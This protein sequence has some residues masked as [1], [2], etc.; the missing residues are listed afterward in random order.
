ML[1]PIVLRRGVPVLAAASLVMAAALA[2]AAESVPA[3]PADPH[4]AVPEA[5]AAPGLAGY[6]RYQPAVP[7]WRQADAL[8]APQGA[9]PAMPH[10]NHPPDGATPT[11]VQASADPSGHAHSNGPMKQV[12]HASHDRHM[13]HAASARHAAHAGHMA[14]MADMPGMQH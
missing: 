3:D 6:Q 11:A 8:A 5:P 1:F 2:H 14:D 7:A 13:D 10:H 4:A 12:G 9:A